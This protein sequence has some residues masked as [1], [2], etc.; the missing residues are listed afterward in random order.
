[1]GGMFKGIQPST[2]QDADLSPVFQL[3]MAHCNQNEV[4]FNFFL[5]HMAH[6]F[7]RPQERTDIAVL[8]LGSEGVGK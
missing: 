7:Q 6:M 3:L 4:N 2:I 1:M 8:M 5:D